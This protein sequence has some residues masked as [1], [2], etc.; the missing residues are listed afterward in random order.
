[1]SYLYRLALAHR[2]ELLRQ[3]AERRRGQQAFPRREA[4]P[5]RATG[6]RPI[7]PRAPRLRRSGAQG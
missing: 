4:P 6:P 1:M 3:A 2:G 7:R 5:I